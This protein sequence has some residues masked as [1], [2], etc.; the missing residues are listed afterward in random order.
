MCENTNLAYCLDSF[1]FRTLQPFRRTN[2][3]N[4]ANDGIVP[5]VLRKTPQLCTRSHREILF[6]VHCRYNTVLMERKNPLTRK[7]TLTDGAT[8]VTGKRKGT[9]I[10]RRQ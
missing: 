3:N 2:G 9:Q 1:H 7:H 5:G 10:S 6:T 8:K 4:D